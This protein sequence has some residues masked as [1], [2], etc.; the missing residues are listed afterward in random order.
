MK[1]F[2][3][4]TLATVCG[5][6]L[7][8]LVSMF[9]FFALLGS[10]AAMGSSDAVTKAEPHSVYC[11]D[12]R[13]S[14]AERTDYDKFTAAM[15]ELA[16]QKQD[17]QYGLNDLVENIRKAK[18]NPNIDGICLKGGKLQMGWA[19]AQTLR[20]EL[21]AFK[22]SGK[23]VI[24]YADFY[25]QLNY[26]LA[27]CADRVL[28]NPSGAIDWHGLS[29]TMAF[30]QR[31]LDKL[32]VEMQ[33]VKVGTFKSAVEPYIRT[34]MSEANRLQMEVLL[35]EVWHQVRA[36]VAESR[37]MSPDAL[38]SLADHYMGLQPAEDYL[39]EGLADSLCYEEG[40][41]SVLTALCGEDYEILSHEDML[42]VVTKPEKYQKDKIAILYAEGTITD[43]TGD[44]I[45]GKDM[46]ETI[47]ELT[48]KENVKA[49]VLR[50]NSP[51]GSAFASEQINHALCLL[52]E[53]KPLVVSMGDYA[54]SGG[55]YISAP[56]DFIFA[57]HNTIT[58]S[59]GIFGVIPNIGGL[60]DKVG[61]DFDALAT[62]KHG[63]L[64]A[65]SVLKGMNE[66][67]RI[68]MQAE[69]NRGYDL[70][71]RRC[72]EGRH[73]SQDSVKV[74]GEGRVWTGIHALQ[75]GL[76]DS[77]GSLDDAVR[78]AAA[79]AEI[80][81]YAIKEYPEEDDEFTKLLK[82]FGSASVADRMV[83]KAVGDERYER[84]YYLRHL[85]TEPSVQARLPYF[86]NIE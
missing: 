80:E 60:T 49:V 63:N 62:H 48:E 65:N 69:I 39:A 19:T 1:Q 21:M 23:F 12:M 27:S 25:G 2:L 77:I 79:L 68:M 26:Y 84:M 35:N 54:A 50:V 42:S 61:L 24:A 16:G 45:V 14:V 13:G 37:N 52:K 43:D 4:Y 85:A 76:V 7:F 86:I 31:L 15:M 29:V 72:A 40:L 20:H 33:I 11:I 47:A 83:R 44:G 81:E 30:Y 28:V 5:L 56:G 22:E 36:D 55:Y 78:K 38:D 75:L 46:V 8:A 67:E 18:D 32:G 74:I 66:E 17:P 10:L 70:F 9:F 71:T 6:L 3:K 82:A 57:E 64:E 73:I 53:K 34:S 41:D 59:I 58:S 51:G